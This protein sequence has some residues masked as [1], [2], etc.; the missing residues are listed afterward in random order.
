MSKA[1]ALKL[2]VAVMFVIGASMAALADPMEVRFA[3][4]GGQSQNG[5]YTY[6][7]YLT[8]ANGPQIPVICDDFLHQSNVGDTWL[9]NITNLGSGD[10]SNTRFNNLTAYQEAGFLLMQI[11][12]SNQTEW[13]NINFA[14]WKIFD[15]NVAM[16]DVPPGTLG[17]DYWYDLAQTTNVSNLD[18]SGVRILTPTDKNSVGGDQE[19]MYLTPEPGTLMLIGSGLIGLFSQRKRLA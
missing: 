1:R 18:F 5:L 2:L 19:F 6:P 15:P 12:D 9:A 16:G 13:G 11:N 17:P 10:L 3:G 4:L 14:I 7:Y 8:I